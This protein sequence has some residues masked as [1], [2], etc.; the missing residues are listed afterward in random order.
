[1]RLSLHAHVHANSLTTQ[2]GVPFISTAAAGEYPMQWREVSVYPCEVRIAT[3][4]IEAAALR[5]RSSQ[6][7]TRDG[8][9]DIKLGPRVANTITLRTC[10]GSRA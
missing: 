6:R 10:H 1:M 9:N 5:D 4:D 8:R 7:D 2:N 3:H